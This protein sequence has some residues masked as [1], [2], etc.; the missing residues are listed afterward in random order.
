M[1]IITKA[2]GVTVPLV[3]PIWVL[4]AVYRLFYGSQ[5]EFE[6]AAILTCCLFLVSSVA[7]RE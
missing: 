1:H 3:T 7:N 5:A 6:S 2:L 4:I